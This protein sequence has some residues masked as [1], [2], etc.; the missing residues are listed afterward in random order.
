MHC[1][2]NSLKEKHPMGIELVHSE[3]WVELTFCSQLTVTSPPPTQCTSIR[4]EYGVWSLEHHSMQLW[5][6]ARRVKVS[7]SFSRKINNDWVG[8]LN[9]LET[10]QRKETRY[11]ACSI[12]TAKWTIWQATFPL[13]HNTCVYS[14]VKNLV[15]LFFSKCMWRSC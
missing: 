3:S 14:W 8:Y 13:Q 5:L 6:C 4:A 12:Q 11:F 2:L 10:G 1:Y 9:S 15:E 7:S